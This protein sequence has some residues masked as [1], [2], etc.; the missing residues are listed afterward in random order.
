MNRLQLGTLVEPDDLGQAFLR[1]YPQLSEVTVRVT[2]PVYH[3]DSD[4]IREAYF[5][6]R[7]ERI[8]AAA[9]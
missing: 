3:Y 6:Y 9:P 2:Q 8:S 5:E 1:Q 4:H 7:Y